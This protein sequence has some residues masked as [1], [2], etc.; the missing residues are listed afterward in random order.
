MSSSLAAFRESSDAEDWRRLMDK[1]LIRRTRSF[2]KQEYA[3]ENEHGQYYIEAPR[4]NN[5]FSNN[6]IQKPAKHFLPERIAKTI[7][8][9]PDSQYKKLFSEETVDTI[10]SLELPRYGLIKYKMP[11]LPSLNPKEEQIFKDLERA[12][13]QPKGFCRVQLFKRLESSGYAFLKSVYHHVLRNYIFLYAI[14]NKLPLPIGSTLN[15][16]TADVHPSDTDTDGEILELDSPTYHDAASFLK[17]LNPENLQHIAQSLYRANEK[18]MKMRPISSTYFSPDLETDLK[19]DTH[20]LEKLL[21]K[22]SEWSPDKDTKLKELELLLIDSATNPDKKLKKNI[23]FTQFKDTAEYLGQKLNNQGLKASVIT[24]DSA[25]KKIQQT[26]R[27]FSPNSNS[28]KTSP[29]DELHIL[30]ATDVLSEGQ[31]LQDCGSVI[32]YDLPW[33][34][35]KL[36]QRAGR[37][38][39]IGQTE[40]QVYCHTFMP[41]DGVEELLRLHQRLQQR[42]QQNQEVLGSDEKFFEGD[43][44]AIRDLYNEKSSILNDDKGGDDTDLSSYALSLWNKEAKKDE[45]LKTRIPNMSNKVYATKHS[46]KHEGVLLFAQNNKMDRLVHIGAQGHVLTENARKVLEIARCMPNET[47]LPHNNSHDNLVNQQ[48]NKMR[49]KSAKIIAQQESFSA[50]S[51]PRY[52]LYNTFGIEIQKLEDTP[53]EIVPQDETKQTPIRQD[54]MCPGSL[55]ATRRDQLET[56][57]DIHDQ[58]HAKPLTPDS[59]DALARMYKQKTS[60]QKILNFAIELHRQNKL[61]DTSKR[62]KLDDAPHIVCSLG[63]SS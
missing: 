15:C 5:R 6:T 18:K 42:L 58:V 22:S 48:L 25:S 37:I 61:V 50:R 10:K 52:K 56:L 43:E 27:N 46:P 29:D 26:V 21:E 55:R 63:L 40:S 33:A 3:K 44:T 1:F 62:A 59:N 24:G 13:T 45:S 35:I 54:V 30:I 51:T 9:K 2:I 49:E 60:H 41:A 11:K 28:Y 19:A 31:N 23:V 57:K 17:N 4:S 34:I 7:K 38:D 14:D 47:K 32:N 39:R 16:C 12:R 20:L 36:V 53:P 8:F